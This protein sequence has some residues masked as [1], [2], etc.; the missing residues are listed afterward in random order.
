VHPSLSSPSHPGKGSED[1]LEDA[2]VPLV[3]VLDESTDL[4][5]DSW[6]AVERHP[7]A[8]ANATAANPTTIASKRA[9]LYY[10][11]VRGMR[12]VQEITL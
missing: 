2:E 8:G 7:P 11:E 5:G 9:I 10:L 4:R 1:D 3:E 12:S 6:T